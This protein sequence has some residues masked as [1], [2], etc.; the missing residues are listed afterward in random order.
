MM[1]LA[2]WE[3]GPRVMGCSQY[4]SANFPVGL[5]LF[6]SRKFLENGFVFRGPRCGG[7]LPCRPPG[8][9]AA[10]GMARTTA[11]SGKGSRP[12]S[13]AQGTQTCRRL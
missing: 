6:P 4:C 3:S 8:S 1:L 13:P 5:K 11:G 10:L 9:P 2:A 7:M 12:R